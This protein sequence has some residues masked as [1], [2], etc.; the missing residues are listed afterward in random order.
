MFEKILDSQFPRM[1]SQACRDINSPFYGCFD[2]N[3]WHYRIRDFSSVMLQQGG[4]TA[5]LYSKVPGYSE[6]NDDLENLAKAAARFWNERAKRHGAFEEYYPREQGYPPLAFSTLAM[7]KLCSEGLVGEEL[8]SEGLK[9]AAR[10]LQKRFESQA[11]NQ[12]VA[13]LAALAHIRKI[14]PSLVGEA[15]LLA[16]KKRTLAL[17]DEAGWY[18]EY[19]GPD[20]GYLS[21]TLDCL[22]DL[23]DVTGD[24]D[25]HESAVKA[26]NFLH[27]FLILRGGGAG[28]HNARNTDY[29]VPYGICR[30]LVQ[31]DPALQQKSE[32]IIDIIYA[33]MDDK[34]HFF[35]AI[36]DRYWSH[37]IGHSVVRAQLISGGSKVR[38][39]KP[40]LM[41]PYSG[42]VSSAGYIFRQ[43]K[44]ENRILVST[45]K[46]GIFSIFTEDKTLFSD[47]GLVVRKGKKQFVNHW[48]SKDWKV[49]EDESTIEV[50]GY[51]FPHREKTSTPFLHFGL[52]VLSLFFGSAL[53]G[54]LR[55]V[56]IF[57][58]KKSKFGFSRKISLESASVEVTD[59]IDGMDEHCEVVRAPRASKRHVASADSWHREDWVLNEGVE[60]QEEIQRKGG[61]IEIYTRILY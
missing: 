13:G 34:N 36:D 2:R 27:A 26:L 42:S 33:G 23:Y 22:W 30:F 51:L 11:G 10:Q 21:V 46:G 19:D 14:D 47:F 3:W 55:R 58:S 28:M 1:L 38:K 32:T 37:Y 9:I 24:K 4:Y 20:L 8:I 6:Y 25:Y 54:L 41:A 43:L 56:L 7:T 35:H 44:G 53:T 61:V 18:T 31:D 60:M 39:V 15:K 40:D 17:Q 49:R 57:K 52:R 5:Y 50:S 59:R 45:L 16:L 48:W 29:I 12:Q